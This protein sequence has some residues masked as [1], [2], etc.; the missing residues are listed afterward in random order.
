MFII[1]LGKFVFIISTLLPYTECPGG[2]VPDFERTFLKLKY[3]D[4]TKITYIRS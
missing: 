4:I 1:F 2:N 3:A